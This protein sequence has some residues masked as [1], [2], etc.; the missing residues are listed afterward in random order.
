MAVLG[1]GPNGH[2]QCHPNALKRATAGLR[3]WVLRVPPY[4]GK[5]TPRRLGPSEFLDAPY[6][7]I[8][9]HRGSCAELA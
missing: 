8:A 9:K 5:E 1:C 6:I 7:E 4:A 3:R 2:R